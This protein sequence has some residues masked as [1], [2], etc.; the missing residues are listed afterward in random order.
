[1]SLH[2]KVA[3]EVALSSTSNEERDRANII[4][5]LV[6]SDA[7]EGGNWHRIVLALASD[8]QLELPGLTD[9]KALLILTSLHVPSPAPSPAQLAVP[10]EFKLNDVGNTPIKVTPLDG[11]VGTLLLSTD[12]LTS[13]F[14]SNA[15]AL[16]GMEVTWLAIGD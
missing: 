15:D 13:L 5:E 12:S 8:L 4:Q 7:Q 16:V 1:M 11:N 9:V 6:R 3:L 14:V 2:L 10:L